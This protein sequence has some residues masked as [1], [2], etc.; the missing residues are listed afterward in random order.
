M[1]YLKEKV[2]KCKNRPKACKGQFNQNKI[3]IY[4]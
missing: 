4:S 2:P 1:K 3:A